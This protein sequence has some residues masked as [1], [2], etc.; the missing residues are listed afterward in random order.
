VAQQFLRRRAVGL[1]GGK[2]AGFGAEI[3][4]ATFGGN[5]R[6]AKEDGAAAAASNAASA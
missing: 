4:N 2:Y 5:A 6:A 3:R 1:R